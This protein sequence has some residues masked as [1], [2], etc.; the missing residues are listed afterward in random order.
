MGSNVE[1]LIKI[2]SRLQRLLCA[3]RYF[4]YAHWKWANIQ[5]LICAI[6]IKTNPEIVP[7]KL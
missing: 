3:L 1:V 2:F 6:K 5:D 4:Y 7:E